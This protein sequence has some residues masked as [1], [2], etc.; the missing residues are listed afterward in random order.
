M[1]R[2]LISISSEKENA[3]AS[4]GVTPFVGDSSS[5]ISSVST[6]MSGSPLSTVGEMTRG[7]PAPKELGVLSLDCDGVGSFA[8][9]EEV[10][11]GAG[12]VL[13]DAELGSGVEVDVDD[14]GGGE[15]GVG[16]E[17]DAGGGVGGS[18]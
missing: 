18:S 15:E 16:D 2:L 6:M 3:K 1:S 17:V 9:A 4:D 5:E 7:S 11:V 14:E 12:V 10:F 8:G 13:D